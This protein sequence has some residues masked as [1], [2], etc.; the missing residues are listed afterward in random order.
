MADL[1]LLTYSARR[2]SSKRNY[3]IDTVS[4]FK[5]MDAEI[6]ALIGATIGAS[7]V[8]VSVAIT[9]WLQRRD[10]H[11]KWIRDKK[12]EAYSNTLRY[13]FRMRYKR[14]KITAEGL[15]YIATEDTK[16]WFDDLISMIDSL[17]SLS[18]FAHREFEKSIA[19]QA[20]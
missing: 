7:L 5:K 15:S 18:I 1:I 17:S 13:L 10:E 12:Q 3:L 19:E 4:L 16:E 20:A 6:V 9:S 2:L 14:S 11:Q 8:I